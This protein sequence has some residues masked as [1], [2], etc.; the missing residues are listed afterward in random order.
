MK[1]PR[2]LKKGSVVRIISTA[3]KIS[4][5]EVEPTI[6]LLRSW[7]L[8]V[9]LGRNVYATEHQFAGHRTLRLQDL[10]EALDD[11]SVDMVWCSR[12]G[13]GTTMLI[14]DLRFDEFIK[15][16]KWVV[17][18]SDI[19]SL[20][21]HITHNLQ[22]AT[23]HAT[24][25]INIHQQLDE[26]SLRSVQ[27]LKDWLFGQTL[28]YDIKPSSLSRTGDA[29]GPIIGGNLSMLYSI[30]GSTSSPNTAGS[31]LFIE[32]LDEY[33]Y[34][35]DRMMVNL[36]R[37]G[38]LDQLSALLVGGM[39]DMNDNTIPYGQ[40]A[41]EIIWEHVKQF[42]YPVYFGFEAGHQSPNLALPFGINASIENN[43][44]TIYQ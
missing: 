16:P 23:L 34:H 10:Q 44:L 42:E 32:D 11:S 24:M 35:I 25:P 12:G 18:Y 17:G 41:K 19:T 38:K 20:L 33:L 5:G 26:S 6:K 31:I 4:P 27:S 29:K 15:H 21:C 8:T 7:G 43:C 39:T 1:K 13:Y 28:S 36:Y 30:L 2:S 3:R 14:D 22:I 40:D 9:Q 37:N